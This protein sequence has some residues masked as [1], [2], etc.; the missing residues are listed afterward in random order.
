[1]QALS[2]IS[3]CRSSSRCSSAVRSGSCNL[4]VD[5]LGFF[6][7]GDSR[8][9]FLMRPDETFSHIPGRSPG[10]QLVTLQPAVQ[11]NKAGLRGPPELRRAK[12][13]R[14]KPPTSDGAENIDFPFL[15]PGT[16]NFFFAFSRK[17][18]HSACC[19]KLFCRF[20]CS[21]IKL[22][23]ESV[24]TARRRVFKCHQSLLESYFLLLCKRN[25]PH[26]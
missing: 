8:E 26:K 21:D 9:S 2:G 13:G 3:Q 14:D 25:D 15:T 16:S 22:S 24:C 17:Q 18:S 10:L 5:D 11:T 20:S 23:L 6:D 12:P 4:S 1:M 7:W 19:G